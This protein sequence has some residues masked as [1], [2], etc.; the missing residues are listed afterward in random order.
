[1][2][3]A[4]PQEID[5]LKSHVPDYAEMAE[6]SVTCE[7]KEEA[8]QLEKLMPEVSDTKEVLLQAE[9]L[10]KR[11]PKLNSSKKRWDALKAAFTGRAYDEYYEVLRD[12]SFRVKRGESMGVI[13]ENGAGK[14]T[15]L[16]LVAGVLTPSSGSL[17]IYG[18][19]AAMLELGA[20]FH[21]EYTGLENI[22]ISGALQGMTNEEIKKRLEGIIDFAG[23]GDYIHEPIKHYSSGMIVRLGF[24]LMTAT[25]PELLITDEVLAVGDESFQKRC[26]TWMEAYLQSGGTILLC[27][28]GMYHIQK[29]CSR[30]LWIERGRIR[31]LGDA[32]SVTRSYLSYHEAKD[33]KD[34]DTAV[35][36]SKGEHTSEYRADWV[37]VLNNQGEE[38]EAI[39]FDDDLLIEGEIYSPDGRMP[40]VGIGFERKGG[41]AVFGLTNE[42]DD[43]ALERKSERIFF[44]KIRFLSCQLIPGE[45]RMRVSVMDP[46]A[47]RLFDN[48]E[49]DVVVRGWRR[50]LGSCYMRHSWEHRH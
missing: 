18:R 13:G 48:V 28:H 23:L 7:H 24:A 38:I 33:K 29:L 5:K 12:I 36:I 19:V 14:S 16:K 34:N 44:F 35:K 41:M 2:K 43:V 17:K 27:S 47:L 50:E 31:Q 37:R 42:M 32:L 46:E 21:P 39:D 11:Y 40:N 6:K 30:A 9:H 15:L 3:I 8:E 49:I 22:R 26:I 4:E 20:G 25:E 10:C 1:M 45:Y